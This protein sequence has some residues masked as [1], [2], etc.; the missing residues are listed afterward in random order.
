MPNKIDFIYKLEGDLGNGI[1]VVEFSPILL[2]LGQ[3]IQEGNRVI[4]PHG[5]EIAVNVKPFQKGSFIVDIS[6]FAE[7]NLQQVIDLISQD[8]VKDLKEVLEWLGIISGGAYSVIQLIKFLKGK[9]KAVERVSPG[10]TRYTSN[11][12][13]TMVVN[14]KIHSLF[15]NPTIQYNIYNTYGKPFDLPNV[16]AVGSF[17]KEEEPSTAVKVTGEEGKYFTVYKKPEVIDESELMN[18]SIVR[19]LLNPKLGSYEG[20]KGPY[21]FTV[22]GNKDQKIKADI[23]DDTFTAN[24]AE[25]DVR[26]HYTDLLDAD[27]TIKQ[28]VKDN[29][30]VS[31]TYEI[32]KIHNYKKAPKQ[33]QLTEYDNG[34]E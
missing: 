11:D 21:Q 14:E 31:T 8:G 18:T 27:V 13:S 4:N 34:Q 5:R 9:P 15:Q 30:V 33:P 7:T 23:T 2:S 1:D 16:E 25:G 24:L 20:G 10:E 12:G 17:I 19:L 29:E 3:L 32:T 22:T 26:L 6:I 28:K